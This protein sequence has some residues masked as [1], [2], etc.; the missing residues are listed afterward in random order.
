MSAAVMPMR[1][2]P[3]LPC[4]SA[5]GSQARVKITK[6]PISTKRLGIAPPCPWDLHHHMALSFPAGDSHSGSAVTGLFFY[7]HWGQILEPGLGLD[8][9]FDLGAQRPW[10][11]VVHDEHPW[12]ILDDDLVH[13]H[14][15][16]I[17]PVEVKLQLR[18]LYQPVH[19]GVYIRHHIRRS[20]RDKGAVKAARESAEGIDQP[21]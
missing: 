6:H 12:G 7:P 20:R 15:D 18:R 21:I 2:T 19:L 16:L 8:V 4:A 14:Q 3:P 5:I 11:Q 1:S 10:V 9:A 13:P 17:L